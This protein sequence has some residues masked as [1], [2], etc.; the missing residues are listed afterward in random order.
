M[1]GLLKT[2]ESG[3]VTAEGVVPNTQRFVEGGPIPLYDAQGRARGHQK[4]KAGSVVISRLNEPLLQSLTQDLSG[5]YI[6]A[7]HDDSDVKKLIRHLSSFEKEKLDD[8]EVEHYQE[9]YPWF[10]IISF[11]SKVFLTNESLNDGAYS[12]V[13]G[14]FSL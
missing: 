11:G 9:Q 12:P 2:F 5:V 7:T 14:E 13:K 4:D 6:H 8:H 1:P 3:S 10:L